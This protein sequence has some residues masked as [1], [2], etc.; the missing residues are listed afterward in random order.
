MVY[1]AAARA[2]YRASVKSAGA[3]SAAAGRDSSLDL[4]KEREKL[5]NDPSEE[6][7]ALEGVARFQLWRKQRNAMDDRDVLA[8]LEK[9]G[10]KITRLQQR[11]NK[12]FMSNAFEWVMALVIIANSIFIAIRADEPE[13]QAIILTDD[14]LFVP[15]FTIELFLKLLTYQL[16]YFTDYWNDLDFFVV[17]ICWLEIIVRYGGGNEV[18]AQTLEALRIFRVLRILRVLRL[19]RSFRELR[20]LVRGIIQ[21]FRALLWV[22]ILIAVFIFVSAVYVTEMYQP[23]RGDTLINEYFLSVSRSM[24]TM[25]QILTLESWAN[26]I[27]RP[28]ESMNP[29]LVAFFVLYVIVLTFGMLNIL[30]AVFV[31][32]TIQM[33]HADDE[34]IRRPVGRERG[35][36]VRVEEVGVAIAMEKRRQ[37]ELLK[38][39]METADTDK[40]GTVTKEEWEVLMSSQD[41][42]LKLRKLG[43]QV[44]EAGPLFDTLDLDESGDIETDE[45][46]NGLMKAAGEAKA[47]D[48]MVIHKQL[49][50]Q[51]RSL[52]ILQHAV[53]QIAYR[54]CGENFE[55]PP[56]P[57]ARTLNEQVAPHYF[58]RRRTTKVV[59]IG[60]DGET[61]D[62]RFR[63]R[64]LSEFP[65]YESPDR[66]SP[67]PTGLTSRD[68]RDD[69]MR[70]DRYS[71][72]SNTAILVPLSP[73]THTAMPSPSYGGSP[74]VLKLS[75]GGAGGGG[76]GRGASAEAS[77]RETEKGKERDA[78]SQ[79]LDR[80]IEQLGSTG[81]SAAAVGGGGGRERQGDQTAPEEQEG[82]GEGEGAVS[83]SERP[84]RLPASSPARGVPRGS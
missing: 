44:Q 68:E 82:G 65:A 16:L 14:F 30:T 7:S 73:A 35:G 74:P 78:S 38:E 75:G 80:A 12:V 83:S 49:E 84:G 77:A 19:L 53:E 9:R 28:L 61:V 46:V 45:F 29:G 54:V 51:R 66:R 15:I 72:E 24:F 10:N 76:G 39:L 27:V 31:E 48:L 43:I 60:Q 40:S 71:V 63:R 37:A 32:T 20:L 81:R 13:N 8:D 56:L 21:S 47:V 33:A 69:S 2:P 18:S 17:C 22:F 55:P 25:F 1:S 57:R 42:Q 50:M 23:H 6:G 41:V 70:A 11:L 26:G 52:D 34:E 4:V 58:H 3:Q 79:D 64:S 36:G 5:E 62:S 67:G 59:P